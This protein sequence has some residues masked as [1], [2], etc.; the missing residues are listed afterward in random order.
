MNDPSTL[1]SQKR[2]RIAALKAAIEVEEAELRGMIA[3]AALLTKSAPPPRAHRSRPIDL[4]VDNGVSKGRQPGSI[5]MRWRAVLWRLDGLGGD[6]TPADIVTA[7][8]ELEG[9]STRPTDAR[10]QMDG[11][12]ELGFVRLDEGKYNVTE[13]FRAKFA[14]SAGILLS[15]DMLRESNAEESEASDWDRV[16]HPADPEMKTAYDL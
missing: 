1:L 2:D 5:S 8:R 4:G 16:D 7:V 13:E 12:V 15:E 9:R 10:R 11:Y 3:M 6:F 14:D